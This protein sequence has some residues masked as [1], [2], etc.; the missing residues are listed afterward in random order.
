[1][2]LLMVRM[3]D[4]TSEVILALD[5]YPEG[6]TLS[7]LAAAIGRSTSSVQRAVSTLVSSAVVDR[8]ETAHPRYRLND[9]APL[10]ALREVA[11]WSLPAGHSDRIARRRGRTADA[12]RRAATRLRREAPGSAAARWVPAAVERLVE[13][14]NPSRIVL[15]GS[16]IKGGARWDSDVDLLVVLPEVDD[17]RAAAIEIRRE[18]RDLP[19]AK[20]IL[21]A[22]RHEFASGRLVPGTAIQEAFADGLTVY[23]RR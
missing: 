2:G 22:S 15:F 16:Q 1:M 20:D 17:R 3:A 14:F 4:V 18:L 10:A 23:E 12:R 5:E 13:R 8:E 21:V 7:E 19:V 9:A 11:R 6:R